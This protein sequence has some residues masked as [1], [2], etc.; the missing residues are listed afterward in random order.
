MQVDGHTAEIEVKVSFLN[1]L[2]FKNG[3]ALSGVGP[4]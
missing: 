4:A 1:E 3:K 2:H